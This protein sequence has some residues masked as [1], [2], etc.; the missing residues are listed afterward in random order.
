MLASRVP[1]TDYDWNCGYGIL[2]NCDMYNWF[3]PTFCFHHAYQRVLFELC[4]RRSA[5]AMSEVFLSFPEGP[6]H[7]R[8]YGDSGGTIVWSLVIG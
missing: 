5:M 4:L 2:F 3:S 6:G 8:R 1:C 7:V